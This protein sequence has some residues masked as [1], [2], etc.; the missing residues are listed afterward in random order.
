MARAD[1]WAAAN[2]ARFE[3]ATLTVNTNE[4][5]QAIHDIVV[6]TGKYDYENDRFEAAR[7]MFTKAA[8][9]GVTDPEPQ[10]YLELLA[11]EARGGN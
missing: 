5:Q 4:F 1:A 11:R 6:A 10:R 8:A 7:A 2:A 3:S 9:D